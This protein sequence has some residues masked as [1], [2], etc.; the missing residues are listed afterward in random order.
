LIFP[1]LKP[2][3]PPS[4]AAAKRK[5]NLVIGTTGFTPAEVDEIKKIIDTNG[6]GAV[7]AS[8]FAIGAIVMMHLATSLPNIL[9]TQKSSNYTIT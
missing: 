6:I 1:W 8:N 2:H 7:M 5:V 3:C 4:V 9:I